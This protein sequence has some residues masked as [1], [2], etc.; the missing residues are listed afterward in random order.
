MK[1]SLCIVSRTSSTRLPKKAL[2]NIINNVNLLDL[3]LFR[4]KTEFNPRSIVLATTNLKQDDILEEVANK[5]SI[6]FFR[7]EE[8]N[9]LDRLINSSSQF[10]ACQN[11]VRITGD[12][13][14]TDPFV[15]KQMIEDHE[16]NYSDHTF[17]KSIP[18]GT[19]AEVLSLDFLKFLV[20]MLLIKIIQN[21]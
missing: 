10:E 18:I 6:N 12:N 11:I 17:T 4:L 14:L 15:L 7:G 9:V 20:E 8:K 2:L 21:T 5:H 13:P 3:L 19:R 1:T 16:R